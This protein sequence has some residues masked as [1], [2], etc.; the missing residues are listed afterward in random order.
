M[1]ERTARRWQS[2]ALPATAEGASDVADAGGPVLRRV[3]VRRWS[4]QLVADTEGRLQVRTLFRE[5]CRRHPGRFEAGQLRTLQ[6]RVREWL[7]Q[8]GPD[9][10]VVLRAGGG[11][12]SGSGV[13]L[14]GRELAEGD[15]R[16]QDRRYVRDRRGGRDGARAGGREPDGT[17]LRAALDQSEAARTSSGTACRARPAVC[18]PCRRPARA[19]TRTATAISADSPG[20]SATDEDRPCCDSSGRS[21]LDVRPRRAPERAL[22]GSQLCR[23]D[24]D[25]L[26]FSQLERAVAADPSLPRWNGPSIPA[27][28]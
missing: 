10:E 15:D 3:G 8:D 6:R 19:P 16:G 4:P 18:R 27:W 20:V 22:T 2:G 26:H 21:T 9:R 25:L 1:S 13:R 24:P 5:L 28:E 7:A 11:S 23:T 17:R 14:H 12:G